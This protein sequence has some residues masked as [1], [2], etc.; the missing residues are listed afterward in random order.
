MTTHIP[1][2]TLPA[3]VFE[4]PAVSVLLPVIAGAGVGYSTRPDQTKKT[5]RA[6]KQPPGNPPAW[7]FGP[8]WTALYATMGYTA[9]RA[10]S[11]GTSS[12]SAPLGL[13]TLDLNKF[14]LA[15][16]WGLLFVVHIPYRTS[17]VKI[18]CLFGDLDARDTGSI[19]A[20]DAGHYIRIKG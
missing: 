13:G 14:E 12:P 17:I 3:F 4:Q 2:L 1:S 20:L 11:I 9:Y 18:Q 6:L 8:V 5:Y 19:G 7:V 15:K 10:W 16:V